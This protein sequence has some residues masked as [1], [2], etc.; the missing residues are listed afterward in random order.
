MCACGRGGVK[1]ALPGVWLSV[2]ESSG[3]PTRLAVS[4][5]EIK[6]SGAMEGSIRRPNGTGALASC[7]EA[8]T[9][10]TEASTSCVFESCGKEGWHSQDLERG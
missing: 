5:A 7:T 4:L 1:A 2:G 9:S 6:S 10:P 3:F 8:L